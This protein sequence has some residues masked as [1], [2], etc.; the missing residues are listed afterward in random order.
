M[1]KAEAKAKALEYILDGIKKQA[2]AEKKAK[3]NG[4]WLSGFDANKSLF[5]EIHKE[6]RAK[7]ERLKDQITD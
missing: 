3:E 2:E 1:T 7:I 5:D 6:T 4:T